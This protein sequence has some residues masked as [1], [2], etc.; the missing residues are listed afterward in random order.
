M[1]RQKPPHSIRRLAPTQSSGRRGTKRNGEERSA[2]MRVSFRSHHRCAFGSVGLRSVCNSSRNL[3]FAP[4]ALGRELFGLKLHGWPGRPGSGQAHCDRPLRL[5]RRSESWPC[6]CPA[7]PLRLP[8]REARIKA[9]S[10]L[11]VCACA[12][13][14][15]LAPWRRSAWDVVP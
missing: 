1:N 3:C 5:D 11:R 14:L 2:S 10:R 8:T 6:R 13:P 12:A 7:S 15:R 4:L 9:G